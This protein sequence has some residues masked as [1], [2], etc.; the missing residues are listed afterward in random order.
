[1]SST[2]KSVT[3]NRAGR[4]KG[5]GTGP[6][7]ELTP[8]EIARL[9]RCAPTARDRALVWLCLGGGLRI[10]EASSLRLA[11]V[12]SDGSVLVEAS[13]AKSGRSRRVYLAPEARKHLAAWLD[14]RPADSGPALFPGR[15]R[16]GGLH[17]NW[18]VQHVRGLLMA[19]GIEGATSHSLRRTH[20]NT[21]RR[22]GLD[23]I[24]IQGQLGHA[25]LSTTAV[26][27][28]ASQ[29]ER[30]AAIARVKF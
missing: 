10:G 19:A 23:L 12:A 26:Y 28:G 21:L 15:D 9:T 25:S 18:A 16:S 6:A 24:V 13:R 4:P 17:P 22:Q 27:M 29:V 7:R 5:T 14:E 20:A 3:A 11:D 8:A 2:K 1:M 30:S